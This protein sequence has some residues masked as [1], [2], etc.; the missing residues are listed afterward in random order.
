M[1]D[2]SFISILKILQPVIDCIKP[3]GRLLAMVKPQFEAGREHVGKGGVV[4]DENARQEAISSVIVAG[5]ALGLDFQ[6]RSDARIQGPKGNQETFVL[7]QKRG[8]L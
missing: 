2:V 5:I 6:G 4:R 3:D 8:S 1:I 7:F